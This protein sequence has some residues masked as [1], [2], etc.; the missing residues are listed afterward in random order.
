MARPIEQYLHN[1]RLY[2]LACGNNNIY[3][4]WHT[5][6]NGHARSVRIGTL[7]VIRHNADRDNGYYARV[8]HPAYVMIDAHDLKN[9][10]LSRNLT[11]FGRSLR[12]MIPLS[13]LNDTWRH[14]TIIARE[15]IYRGKFNR[16]Q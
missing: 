6:E 13:E 2:L 16:V 14:P 4:R 15:A 10:K 1:D 11:L 3:A 12:L 7:H 9:E 5:L 8:R